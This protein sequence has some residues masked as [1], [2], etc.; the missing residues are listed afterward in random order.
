MKYVALVGSVWGVRTFEAV[1]RSCPG[2]WI[3][4]AGA[5]NLDAVFAGARYVF[6]LNW[7]HRVQRHLVEAHEIV[8]FHCTALPYG[9]GGGPIE[10]LI[11]RGHTETVITAHRMVEELDAGPVYATRGPVSLAG[12]KG[13]IQARFVV[14]VTAMIEAIVRDEPVPV[15]QV[16]EPVVFRRLL[17]GEYRRL[18]EA[19][20]RQEPPRQAG[21][22]DR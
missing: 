10:N 17:Y 12:T 7:S 16:G 13:E 11:L 15:P 20:D 3:C 2:E 22:G 6:A 1:S 18:W 5:S 9:R 8:N 21:G 19:R 14:P 4:T